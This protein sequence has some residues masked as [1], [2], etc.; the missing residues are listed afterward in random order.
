MTGCSYNNLWDT[1]VSVYR[2]T[3]QSAP[4]AKQ[5]NQEEER[6]LFFNENDVDF[7]SFQKQEEH[8]SHH[9]AQ[10]KEIPGLPGSKV[11]SLLAF[12]DPPAHLEKMFRKIYFHTD[13]YLP[14]DASAKHSL[15]KIAHYLKT[16]PNIYV[17]LEGHTDERASEAYNL[18]LGAR[19]SNSIRQLLI[20]NGISPDRI[21]PVSYGK[22]CP[23]YLGHNEHSW[24]K[25]R[26]VV[27]KIYDYQG[28]TS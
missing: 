26:R 9:I 22:E 19:R 24:S 25:N 4:D 14:K 10:S 23:E 1:I 12:Q 20:H 28:K 21:F 5:Q 13:Q 17:V 6:S 16:H 3:P 7:I 11:P 27:F 2:G 18:S 15:K 8:P